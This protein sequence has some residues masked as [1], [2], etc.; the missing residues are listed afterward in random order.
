M[1]ELVEGESQHTYEGCQRQQITEPEAAVLGLD[2]FLNL[3]P[4]FGGWPCDTA[5]L[6][7]PKI[8]FA[9][10]RH[11]VI[12][13]WVTPIA[14]F[15][16]FLAR[17]NRTATLFSLIPNT[18]PISACDKPSSIKTIICCERQAKIEL[19]TQDAPVGSSVPSAHLDGDADRPV[20]RPLP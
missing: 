5:P 4:E 16:A 2:S 12:P 20:R 7:A 15:K 17:V 11:W 9:I 18:S 1:A 3:A 13:H 6:F 8:K 10:F 19:L 14:S